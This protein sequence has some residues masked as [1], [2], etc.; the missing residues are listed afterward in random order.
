MLGRGQD[1]V[2]RSSPLRLKSNLD[3]FPCTKETGLLLVRKRNN[4][5]QGQTCRHSSVVSLSKGITGSYGI[6]GLG[7]ISTVL[8]LYLN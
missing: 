5:S 6:L 4:K 1:E 8:L 2:L 3:P 7:W